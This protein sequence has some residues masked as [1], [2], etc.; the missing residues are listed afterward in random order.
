M[1]ILFNK[2]KLCI[3]IISF[4]LLSCEKVV[5][6]DLNLADRQVVVQANVNNQP[7]PYTVNLNYSVSY[8]S[9]NVFPAVT[10]AVVQLSD[11]AGNTETL[12]EVT[13]GVYKTNVFN[14]VAG[15]TYNLQIQANNTSYSAFSSMPN[16]VAIDSFLLH[17]TYNK[18]TN[19]LTGYRVVCKF[20]DPSGTGNFYRVVVGSNDVAA[21]GDRTSRII[22]DKLA[23]G[24][25]LSSTFS[26]K[27]LSGDTVNIQL[28]CIDKS[29]YD[30]YNTL[31][32]AIGNTGASQF[33]SSLPAN[34]TNNISNHGLGYFS[35][36]SLTTQTLVIP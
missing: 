30:F 28:Q 9:D 25:L 15:R 18:N 35:A 13:S 34:P 8:Y 22:E 19:V 1:T 2:H 21:L 4:L 32:N 24:Q 29:T 6:L 11:D 33:I 27:L 5:K 14:G 26:T 31:N 10:G 12:S 3:G 20:T 17:P 36:Y 23:D 16:P 7:G